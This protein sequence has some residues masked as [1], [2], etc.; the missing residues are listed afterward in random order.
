MPLPWVRV[1][2]NLPTHEKI[3][4]LASLGQK[5]LAAAFVYVCSITYAG[6]HDTSGFIAKAALPFVHGTPAM[7]RLLVEARLWVP[8]DG[9]W[10]IKNW[11]DRNV[12]GAAQ[13]AIAEATSAARSANGKKGADARWNQ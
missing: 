4:G 8:V 12:V 2:T 1:D 9:G 3:L 7:A 5:G 11:G 13:Q 10:Q 6:G